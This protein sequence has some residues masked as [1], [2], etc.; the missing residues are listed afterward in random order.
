MAA[1]EFEIERGALLKIEAAPGDRLRVQL[2][3]V[4][5]TQHEDS[6]DYVLRSGESMILSGKGATLAMAYKR[7]LLSWYPGDPRPQARA[8]PQWAHAL[9]RKILA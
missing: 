3:D 1:R 5:I 2:G 7:T 9:L 8:H 6:K 4:W